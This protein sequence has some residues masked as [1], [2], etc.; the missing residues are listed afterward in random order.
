LGRQ[1]KV[2]VIDYGSLHRVG[3]SNI[4]LKRSVLSEKFRELG[5]EVYVE[6]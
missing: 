5:S 3:G 1:A 4:T 2:W 6:E